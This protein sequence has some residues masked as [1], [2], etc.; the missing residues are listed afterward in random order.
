MVG[1]GHGP[2]G[3]YAY[4]DQST[5]ICFC[6]KKLTNG[7]SLEALRNS[8]DN[9]IARALKIGMPHSFVELLPPPNIHDRDP[10]PHRSPAA[11]YIIDDA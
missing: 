1:G 3:S 11:I 4:E 5:S 7:N 2:P 10:L 6:I 8:P 9:Y